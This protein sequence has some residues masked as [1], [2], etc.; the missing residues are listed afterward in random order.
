MVNDSDATRK[1]I[2]ERLASAS[3]NLKNIHTRRIYM[4]ALTIFL[5]LANVT[6]FYMTSSI[7]L[8]YIGGSI[9]AVI[10]VWLFYA[11]R[12]KYMEWSKKSL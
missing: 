7:D 11:A 9:M 10:L 6:H 12:L 3:T 5:I 2:S 8:H 4:M 1:K